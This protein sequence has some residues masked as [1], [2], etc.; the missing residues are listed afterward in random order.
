MNKK[1]LL[2]VLLNV[3]FILVGLGGAA[4]GT[5]A[6]FSANEAF[7]ATVSSFQVVAPEGVNFE[8]YYL[9]HFS[10]S[11]VSKDGNQNV[12]TKLFSGYQT[13]Y[14][15]A[16]VFEMVDYDGEGHPLPLCYAADGVTS[17]TLEESREDCAQVNHGY[18]VHDALSNQDTLWVRNGLGADDFEQGF[19]RYPMDIRNLW[20][21]RKL[22]YAI[23]TEDSLSKLTLASGWHDG[24]SASVIDQD[25]NEIHLSWAIN[26][27]GMA[28]TV[29]KTASVTNDIVAAYYSNGQG[30]PQ[31]YQSYYTYLTGT[32]VNAPTDC[33]PYYPSSV[34]YGNSHD[35]IDGI[36]GGQNLRTV[37]FFTI[38]FS[39]DSD[40]FYEYTE[41]KNEEGVVT[42]RYYDKKTTGNS[43][44]YENLSLSGLQFNLS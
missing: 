37:I 22:T 10:V 12:I 43:N 4:T 24:T 39:N 28:T 5:I 40:T 25:G 11:S 36:P 29:N 41:V 32:G 13:D 30:Q 33:F 38:E 2:V 20:P 8:M 15:N 44:C 42:R 9:N 31:D 23:V 17:V 16:P 1:T 3:F 18:L 26:M 35:I 19:I 14:N 27:Y 21:A 34:S 7:T 6:W